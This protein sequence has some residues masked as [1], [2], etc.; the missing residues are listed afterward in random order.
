MGYR[1]RRRFLSPQHRDK[2]FDRSGNAMPTAWVSGQVVGVWGQRQDGSVVYGLFE[3]ID[4]EERV[5]LENERDRLSNFLDG[6]VLP[7]RSHTPF[8]RELVK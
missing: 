7:Q 5:L 4:E 3:A 6:E 2:V 1:D 8:T